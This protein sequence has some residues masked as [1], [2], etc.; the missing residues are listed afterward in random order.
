MSTAHH[1]LSATES[2]PPSTTYTRTGDDGTSTL[3]DGSRTDKASPLLSAYGEVEDASAAIGT[4][5]AQ[6][7]D[8]SDPVLL[9]LSRVQNDLIDLAA[10]LVAPFGGAEASSDGVAPRIDDSYIARLERACD[11]YN[12]DL[13]ALPGFLIPGGTSTAALLFQARTAVRGA[14]RSVCAAH[15]AGRVNPLLVAYLN[16]LSSLL[17]ILARTS[18]AEHGDTLWHPG[19]TARLTD[20]EL[21]EPL[22]APEES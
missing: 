7:I 9:V 19:F 18:N 20:T 22:S 16:R 4:A 6:S 15:E 1:D 3:G 21:W 12:A 10:D 8:L 2:I 5:I 11:R 17:F 13:P 14:E